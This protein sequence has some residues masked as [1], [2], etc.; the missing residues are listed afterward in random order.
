MYQTGLLGGGD[1][2]V[3]KTDKPLSFHAPSFKRKRNIMNKLFK[4]SINKRNTD[5]VE[6]C[7][8]N[9]VVGEAF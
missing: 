6:C 2:P 4:K 3:N 9:S 8:G 7:E 5:C 1:I